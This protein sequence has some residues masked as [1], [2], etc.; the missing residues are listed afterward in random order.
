MTG[1]HKWNMETGDSYVVGSKAT[2]RPQLERQ[3]NLLD[4]ADELDKL[5]QWVG[6]TDTSSDHELLMEQNPACVCPH[7]YRQHFRAFHPNQCECKY[8]EAKGPIT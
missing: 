8:F 2:E 6:E 5:R 4:H 7:T 1:Q 3:G